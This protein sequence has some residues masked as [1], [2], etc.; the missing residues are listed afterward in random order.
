MKEVKKT[1]VFVGQL[2]EE[3]KQINDKLKVL[4]SKIEYINK[5]MEKYL[6][7]SA[8]LREKKNI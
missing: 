1:D 7:N 6:D 2:A 5:E 8:L 4:E 3:V